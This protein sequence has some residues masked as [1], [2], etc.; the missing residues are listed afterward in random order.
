MFIY[1]LNNSKFLTHLKV[2]KYILIYENRLQSYINLYYVQFQYPFTIFIFIF[3][4]F[5]GGDK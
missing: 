2:L 3:I 4:F 1:F 5:W